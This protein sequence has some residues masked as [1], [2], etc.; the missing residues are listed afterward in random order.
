MKKFYEKPLAELI[1]FELED[2]MALS[3]GHD[4][5]IGEDSN[6]RDEGF[7]DVSIDLFN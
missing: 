6:D 5:V 7:G 3:L 4:Y 1:A 2:V